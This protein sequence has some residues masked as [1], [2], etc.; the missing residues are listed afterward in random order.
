MSKHVEI[1]M[2]SGAKYYLVSTD[3]KKFSRQDID[4]MI[5]GADSISIKVFTER[6]NTSPQ[7]YINPKRI[8]SF[9]LVF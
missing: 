7:V 5:S 1:T 4:Y 8:E 6:S 9:K 3:E 2:S